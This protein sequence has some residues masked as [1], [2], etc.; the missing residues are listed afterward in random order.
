MSSL[1]AQATA[2]AS[3]TAAACMHVARALTSRALT[4]RADTLA[5]GL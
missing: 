5:V 3:A 1:Q 4:R 2:T